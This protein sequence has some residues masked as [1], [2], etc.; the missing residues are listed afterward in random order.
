[1]TAPTQNV[2][3][4]TISAGLWCAGLVAIGSLATPTLAA[5]PATPPLFS[6]VPGV[7]ADW[8]RGVLLAAGS[9]AADLYAAS[10]EVARIKAERLA[11][12]RAEARLRRALQALGHEPRLRGKVAP[13]L[14]AQLDP[15]QAK[16]AHIEYAATGSV[17]LQLEL[18]LTA[19]APAAP[20]PSE[21][22]DGGPAPAAETDKSP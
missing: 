3:R 7:Q 16:V 15:A 12:S 13:A 1:M 17:S 22:R 21:A 20:S 19:A 6:V 5:P 18:A 2:R 4:R 11:K 9:C 14:L 8:G 10:A